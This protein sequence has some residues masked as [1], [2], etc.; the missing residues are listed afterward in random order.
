MHL[1]NK[2]G[3]PLLQFPHF[4]T[5]EKVFHAFTTR[6]GGSSKVPFESLNLGFNTGDVFQ[7]V[8]HNRKKI[9]SALGWRLESV[10][11]PI[12]VH[13]K[14]VATVTKEI[15]G[16]GAYDLESALPAADGLIT[17]EKGILL[18]IK[19]ADCFPVFFYDPG[20][21]A[22]GVFWFSTGKY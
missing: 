19:V 8:L 14:M 6:Q 21:Q 3:I 1:V 7:R 9:L 22:V 10:V 16:R 13:G 18:M 15:K 4:K 17:K 20:M 2:N 5:F 12:Q 11:S